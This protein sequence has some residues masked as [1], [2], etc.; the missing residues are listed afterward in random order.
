MALNTKVSGI[1]KAEKTV[2][3]YKFGLMVHYTKD[4]GK[5]I[6]QTEEGD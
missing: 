2:G 6:K 4:T 5:M 3:A 1:V